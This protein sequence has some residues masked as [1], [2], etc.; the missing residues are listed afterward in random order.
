MPIIVG[1][2]KKAVDRAHERTPR[3]WAT[4][5]GGAALGVIVVAALVIS[6][7]SSSTNSAVGTSP[8]PPTA[9]PHDWVC[10]N[11]APPL[12]DMKV[13][14]T[15]QYPM[16]ID[17]NATY[18]AEVST[19][20]GTML[21][22]LFPQ[23]APIAVNNFVNLAKDGFYTGLIFHRIDKSLGIIQ[24]GDPGCPVSINTCGRGGPGYTIA[25]EFPNGLK[26]K[27]GTVAMASAGTPDSSGSQFEIVAA[28]SLYTMPKE[29]TIFGELVGRHSLQVAQ[30]I[31]SVPTKR[32]PGAPE[33][34]PADFSSGEFVYIK[35]IKVVTKH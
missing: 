18:E 4:R 34:A 23:Q 32:A 10:E 16:T 22:K 1:Q 19:S 30:L 15:T 13:T 14:R 29:R 8:P 28:K 21:I 26:P 33:S 3:W 7:R 27:V 12:M 35:G 31:L 5:V 24:A 11:A 6:A 25:D 2:G 9:S 20:C 17:R